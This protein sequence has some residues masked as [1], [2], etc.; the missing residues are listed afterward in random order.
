MPSN[1]QISR[2]RSIIA[3]ALLGQ[4]RGEQENDEPDLQRVRNYLKD[5]A[6]REAVRKQYTK[7]IIEGQTLLEWLENA[8]GKTGP[9]EWED[10]LGLDPS[11]YFQLGGVKPEVNDTFRKKYLLRYIDAVLAALAKK[12]KEVG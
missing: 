9:K 4:S 8:L 11:D 12:R 3:S 7:A 6:F 5:I 2:F 1:A 10:M